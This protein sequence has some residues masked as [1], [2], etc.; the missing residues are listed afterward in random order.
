MGKP[1]RVKPSNL[2]ESTRWAELGWLAGHGLKQT[3]IGKQTRAGVGEQYCGHADKQIELGLQN[4]IMSKVNRIGP[5]VPVA[6]KC[7]V[8]RGLPPVAID[9]GCQG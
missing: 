9:K 6:G 8:R 3:N 1:D 7:L 5:P 2:D 4:K